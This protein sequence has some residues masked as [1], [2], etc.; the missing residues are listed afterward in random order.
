MPTLYYV[1]VTL[2]VLAAMFWLGGLFFLGIVGAPIL[3]V[4]EPPALRAAL[5][6]RLG[7]RFRT[8]GWSAIV[9]LL[10]TGVTNLYYRNWLRWD[11]VFGSPDFWSTGVGHSLAAKLA[12]V[13]VMIVVAAIHDFFDGP[14]AARATPGS[15]EALAL[16]RRA[17]SL[18][19]V[20]AICGLLLVIVAVRLARGV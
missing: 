13:T 8:L 9:V 3:R 11:G 2:H 20:T 4:V 1:S 14:R 18:A 19:R 16:R 6:D 17:A 15:T 5:F 10:L 12:L 7:R